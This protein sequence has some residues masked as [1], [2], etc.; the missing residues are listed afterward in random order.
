MAN[1]RGWPAVVLL[2]VHNVRVCVCVGTALC[3]CVWARRCACVCGHGVV[4]V[5]VYGH[6]VVRVR[7]WTRCCDTG[8]VHSVGKCTCALLSVM[9]SVVGR[10]YYVR[11]KQDILVLGI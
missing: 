5:C 8:V 9:A 2:H 3:V 4:R 11:F 6:G 10:N 1:C 7:V